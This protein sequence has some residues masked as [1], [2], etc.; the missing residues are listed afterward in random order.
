MRDGD[1]EEGNEVAL[2]RNG[3]T[4]LDSVIS[5][6]WIQAEHR[7]DVVIISPKLLDLMGCG[8]RVDVFIVF[9]LKG[10]CVHSVVVREKR[11]LSDRLKRWAGRNVE[12]FVDF[13]WDEG[14]HEMEPLINR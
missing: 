6:V 5:R 10:V 7:G 13:W 11:E 14:V 9:C 1:T 3:S 2:A 4:M 12:S 8:I